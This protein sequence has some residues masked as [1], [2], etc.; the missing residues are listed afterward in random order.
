MAVPKQALVSL[1]DSQFI[2]LSLG[3]VNRCNWIVSLEYD[4]GRKFRYSNR[5]NYIRTFERPK[6][7]N[8]SERSIAHI[9]QFIFT[10]N[11]TKYARFGDCLQNQSSV[12]AGYGQTAWFSTAFFVC[13]GQA[14]SVDIT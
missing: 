14:K 1:G 8:L 12:S 2:I 10:L 13:K 11:P 6:K 3:S 9:L 4:Y 5:T 7:L